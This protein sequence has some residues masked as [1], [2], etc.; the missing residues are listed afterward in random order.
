VVK[1]TGA[2]GKPITGQVTGVRLETTGPILE[3][4]KK[5]LPVEMVQEVSLSSPATTAQA[6]SATTTTNPGTQSTSSSSAPA[7]DPN[8]AV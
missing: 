1:G 8:P 4:G 5:D 3:L 6:A 7:A 2:D